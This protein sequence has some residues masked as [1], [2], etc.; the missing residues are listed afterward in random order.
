[1][2]PVTADV[3]AELVAWREFC[4]TLAEL[5]ERFLGPS[6]PADNRDPAEAIQHLATQ[7]VCW[8]GDAIAVEQDLGIHRLNDLLTPWGGPNADNVYRYAHIDDQGTYRLRGQMKSCEEFLMAFRVGN[9][10]QKE[11]GTLGEATA[12]LLGI[13][14]GSEV[15]LLLSPSGEGGLAIPPGTR[16]LSIREYYFDWRP[17]EGATLVLERI[18]GS[19]SPNGIVE[20]LGAAA[21]QLD[22]SLTFWADYMREARGR[23][24]D[25]S[26]IPPR[27]EPRGL[28]TMLYSFCFWSLRPDQALIVTFPKPQARM[29]SLQLYQLGWFEALDFGRQTSLNQAQMVVGDDGTVTAVLSAQD[30]G[31]ANWLDTEGREEG[32]LTFRGA[33]LTA[34]APQASTQLVAFAEVG[35]F[36]GDAGSVDPTARAAQVEARREHLRWRFRT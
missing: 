26:F 28:Q 18:D 34:A 5:G 4:A 25:N 6:L 7:T 33:W 31:V 17:L 20:A 30:P 36:V 12:T 27:K 1:V 14:S 2:L 10:H 3:P 21:E 23:G 19:P 32:L 22:R 9:L 15:D 8:L 16:M 35:N 24:E 29:W 13:T 11:S